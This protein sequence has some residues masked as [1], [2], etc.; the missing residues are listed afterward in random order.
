M[1]RVVHLL[2]ILTVLLCG[3]HLSPAEADALTDHVAEARAHAQHGEDESPSDTHTGAAHAG[4]HHCPIA[5]D[6]HPAAALCRPAPLAALLFD[7]PVTRLRSLATA[8]PTQPP[9]A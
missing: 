9:S 6:P 1:R 4:H 5:P 8:P 2:V 7:R 3:S